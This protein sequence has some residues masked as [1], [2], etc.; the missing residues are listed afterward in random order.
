MHFLAGKN[1]YLMYQ[2]AHEDVIQGASGGLGRS[3]G[4]AQAVDTAHVPPLRVA[5]MPSTHVFGISV[6]PRDQ[7][8]RS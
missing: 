3:W 1:T 8:R 6:K 4:W 7:L 5:G 2:E